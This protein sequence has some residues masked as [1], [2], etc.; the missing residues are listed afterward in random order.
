MI[1][2]SNYLPNGTYMITKNGD[3][4]KRHENIRFNNNTTT[5]A[6]TSINLQNNNDFYNNN[7]NVQNLVG[8]EIIPQT[9]LISSN[10]RPYLCPI[11]DHI[12][13]HDQNLNDNFISTSM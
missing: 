7:N 6:A 13:I 10:S 8:T 12:C 1:E 3:R 5:E 2:G 11:C 4:I 9:R